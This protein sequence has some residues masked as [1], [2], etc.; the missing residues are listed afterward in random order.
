M[1][2]RC[3][4]DYKLAVLSYQRIV[5]HI[6]RWTS[7]IGHSFNKRG[8]GLAHSPDTPIRSWR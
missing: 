2:L 3:D 6:R 4:I 8:H 7:L 5:S 1:Y